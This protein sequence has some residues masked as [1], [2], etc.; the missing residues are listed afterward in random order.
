MAAENGSD[1][2][3]ALLTSGEDKDIVLNMAVKKILD[4]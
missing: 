1:E 3:R 4:E 2:A